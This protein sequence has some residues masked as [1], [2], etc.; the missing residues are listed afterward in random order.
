MT[1][2][3]RHLLTVIAVLAVTVLTACDWPMA[4]GGPARTGFN[5]GETVIGTNNVTGLTLRWSQPLRCC[6][7]D[8]AV[9][10][11]LVYVH[12]SSDAD[13]RLVALDASTGTVRWSGPAG[14][15]GPATAVGGTVYVGAEANLLALD[16]QTGHQRWSAPLGESWRF[17]PVVAD[18]LVYASGNEAGP[19]LRAFNAETGTL[20]WA[21]SGASVGSDPTVANGL[22]DV[23]GNDG[24]V[25]AF[26]ART[27]TERWSEDGGWPGQSPAAAGG[28]VVASSF[29]DVTAF[30]ATSGTVRWTATA[31]NASAPAIANGIIYY[32]TYGELIAR[33]AATGRL[34]WSTTSGGISSSGSPSV[35]NGVVYLAGGDHLLTA[36]DASTGAL[37]WTTPTGDGGRS[38]PVIANGELFMV[39]A[40]AITAFSLPVAAAQLA[41]TPTL[42]A[43]FGSVLDGTTSA[44]VTLTVENIGRTPASR[45]SISITGGASQFRIVAN[46]CAGVALA[47][48]AHC[49]I[50]VVFRPSRT[51][52]QRARLD[53][54]ASTG[55]NTHADLSGTAFPFRLT[56]TTADFG[57][58]L[59]GATDSPVRTFTVT[60]IA[61]TKASVVLNA[62][63]VG[64]NFRLTDD[65]CTG[66]TLPAAGSCTVGAI[67]T[68]ISQDVAAQTG[69]FAVSPPAT[70][71]PVSGAGIATLHG[72]VGSWFVIDGTADFGTTPVGT[73]KSQTYTVKNVGPSTTSGLSATI[74]PPS[75]LPF[76]SVTSDA[77]S[78]QA[79]APDAT[80]TVVVT[81]AP[82][83]A[84]P[85]WTSL[86]VSA[87]NAGVAVLLLQG[88]GT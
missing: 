51:G 5:A 22:V 9:A 14:S 43:D 73:T 67:F 24:R 29:S 13:H 64:P 74:A 63:E 34:R 18:G 20:V 80:C 71:N 3:S 31:A 4:R 68:P 33:D 75:L 47:G 79:L 88:A 19:T 81:F 58:R 10:G 39:S 78:G 16:A 85:T 28:L 23:S 7:D 55:G 56:P 83:Y 8:L 70:S 30:D 54:T 57:S 11:A 77:C 38:E 82:R 72:S 36:V 69:T 48:G 1:A 52:S 45:P 25:H 65:H 76:G 62:D 12:L 26:D 15:Q 40:A 87:P 2:L 50:D 21:K 35:A 17:S 27:G 66:V 60:N 32:D 59:I 61:S 84:Y 6:A 37:L 42:P 44:P 53:V 46:S 49:T 41:I 86:S